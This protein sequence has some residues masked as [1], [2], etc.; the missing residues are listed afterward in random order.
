M[1]NPQ[2]GGGNPFQFRRPFRVSFLPRQLCGVGRVTFNQQGQAFIYNDDAGQPVLFEAACLPAFGC[3][4]VR[5]DPI[6]TFFQND[7]VIRRI[8]GFG[9]EF[10]VVPAK[11]GDIPLIYVRGHGLQGHI[12][13]VLLLIPV[14]VYGAAAYDPF[15]RP[16]I[17]RHFFQ[18]LPDC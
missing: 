10:T 14:A 3:N 13:T 1:G 15:T 5:N 6:D 18:D 12:G 7:P 17:E 16:D 11:T 2:A 8:V 4:S 9:V